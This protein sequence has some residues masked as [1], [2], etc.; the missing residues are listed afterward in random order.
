MKQT[1][2]SKLFDDWSKHYDNSITSENDDFP[3]AGYEMILEQVVSLADIKPNMRILDLGIGTG[4]LATRFINKDCNVW[5]LDF[6]A[7][8]LAQ[9]REK[10]PQTNLV[11]ADLLGEWTKILQPTFDRVVSSYVFHEFNL[12]TKMG[13]LQKI[14]SQCLSSNGFILVAD[15]AFPDVDIRTAAS[16]YWADYWDEDEYY[17]AMD[18]TIIACEKIGLQVVYKQVSNCGGVFTFTNRSAG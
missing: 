11:Q 3:F 12:E 9:T 16:Q 5:G 2:R 10:L 1:N 7:E 13:L 17:W 14:L 4:N 8:M 6:S 15:I 18:E